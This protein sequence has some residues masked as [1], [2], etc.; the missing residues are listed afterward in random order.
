MMS[1]A[2]YFDSPW[3]AE[4]G[5][6]QR[7]QVARGGAGL[8]L[9]PGERLACTAR[10][11][12]LSTMTVLGAPGE[13]F[14]LTHSALRG[15][16]G[17]PTTAQIERIDPES[18]CTLA[19]SP[20]LDGGPMWPGGMAVHGNGDIYLVYGRHA[21]RLGRDCQ[22]RQQLRLP[23][24]EP[25]NSFVVLDNGLLVT[26]NLSHTHRASLC[27]LSPDP[28]SLVAEPLLCP[29]PSVARLSA[30]GNSVYV[31]GV[32]SV[33]RFHWNSSRQQLEFD[34]DW[35]FN[36]LDR[37]D[38]SFGWDAVITENDAWFMDNGNHRYLFR[39]VGAGVSSTAN[40]LIR[41]SLKDAN[42]YQLM[43]VCGLPEGSITNP[44][45]VMPQR[46]I[47]VG[48]DS[49]NRVLRGWRIA[50]HGGPLRL[51]WEKSPF[52]TASHLI[53]YPD[54]GELVVNDYR[55]FGEEVAVL[56]IETGQEL[57]RV[58]VGGLHQG[59]VFPSVGWG[60]DL[61]WC[62]MGRLARIFIP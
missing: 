48:F 20:R 41:V 25:Y 7:L 52:G 38:Q 43:D 22:P 4:D 33:F 28:L 40:R 21:H 5:G 27:V 56:K 32:R 19:R 46:R 58:R 9:Q 37:P 14:L 17:L 8:N 39:M 18:L 24:N 50:P 54:S 62:S 59:V 10:N 49:S 30:K 11:T 15:R 16:L 13:V 1:G 12:W 29:E 47:V 60:R 31:I 44:P 42:D 2:G 3:P 51:L 61:Y 53:G 6:P 45:L 26:K 55:R 36:Y 57:G 35:H 34:R 23:E